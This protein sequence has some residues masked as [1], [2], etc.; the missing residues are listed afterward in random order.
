MTK[1]IDVDEVIDYTKL[2]RHIVGAI[3]RGGPM[4]K[5]AF[6][7]R[8][9]R[10]TCGG[11]AFVFA[12]TM[13]L[14][15]VSAAW[16]ESSQA[17]TPSTASSL[18]APA[19]WTSDTSLE[20]SAGA[21][22]ETAISTDSAAATQTA[23]SVAS[24]TAALSTYLPQLPDASTPLAAAGEDSSP[25]ILRELESSRT[26]ES[27]TYLMSDGSLRA[28][29]YEQ[30]IHFRNASGKWQDI[31]ASLVP[32]GTT[33]MVH[34]KSS[35]YDE[36]I[37]SADVTDTP[38]SV[39]HGDWSL[40]LR[41]LGAEQGTLSVLGDT[42][43]YPLAMSDTQL[44]Y[45]TGANKLK[46]T[47]VL[48]SKDAPDTFTFFMSVDNL[49]V[50]TDPL[51]GYVLYDKRN[52]PAGRIEPLSVFDS[53]S[54][55]G[56]DDQG[57]VCE[58]ANMKITPAEGGAYVSYS[59]SRKWLDDPARVYP[60]QV[61]P[62]IIFGGSDVSVDTFVASNYPSSSFGSADF[63]YSGW[64][65]PD[66]NGHPTWKTCRSIMQF[67]L[68]TILQG[69]N[70]TSA[71]LQLW[72]SQSTGS[73][74]A[75]AHTVT[76]GGWGSGSTWTS[77]FGN[78]SLTYLA[79]ASTTV[80]G[81]GYKAWEIGTQVQRWYDGTQVNHGL[82]V[83]ESN[84]LSSA[85]KYHQY[86]SSDNTVDPSSHT[87]H[88]IVNYTQP[89]VAVSGI[90]STYHTGDNVTA[91]VTVVS[92]KIT[93][94][95]M[96]AMA[97]GSQRGLFRF[98][99]FVPPS[100]W[101]Y[102][103]VSGGY[104]SY[105]PNSFPAGSITPN[106]AAC[107]TSVG[108][109]T[110]TVNFVYGIGAEYGAL[111][112]TSIQVCDYD[113]M[114]A[115]V[116]SG[117]YYS[118]IPDAVGSV[119]SESTSTSGWFTE[120]DT[121]ADGVNDLKDDTTTGRGSVDLSWE[122]ANNAASYNIYLFDGVKYDKVGSTP[123]TEWTTL[124]KAI[125]PGDTAISNLA[126]G[127]GN[128]PFPATG[129]KDLR[130]DP[131]PLYSKM[132]GSV[133]NLDPKYYFKVTAVSGTNETPVS[134][135][136]TA[137]P[138]TLPNRSIR[139]NDDPQHAI[140][141][142]GA[143]LF[144][145]QGSA[146]LERGSLELDVTDLS[147]AS[148]GP[149]A[150]LSRHYSSALTTATTYAPGWRFNFEKSLISQG[151]TKIYTDETGDVHRFTNRGGTWVAPNGLTAALA[152]SGSNWTITFKDRS[153]L[154]FN[155]SGQLISESDAHG[156]A[157]TVYYTWAVGH[158]YITAANGQ[159]IDVSMT[160][161]PGIVT[162]AEYATADGTRV[163]TYDGGS[164]YSGVNPTVVTDPEGNRIRY[165][166]GSGSPGYQ[167]TGSPNR[168]VEMDAPDFLWGYY[169][170]HGPG[171]NYADIAVAWNFDYD[172]SSRLT[173]WNLAN[174][175][176]NNGGT[177]LGV[178]S[179]AYNGASATVTKDGSDSTSSQT[180]SW[181]PN[182]QLSSESA[183]LD[184]SKSWS[185]VYGPTM[186]EVFSSTPLEHTTASVLD[187]HD[188]VLTTTDEIEQVASHTYDVLDRELTSTDPRGSIETRLYSGSDLATETKSLTTTRTAVTAWSHNASGAVTQERLKIDE[189][190]TAVTDYSA[191]AANGTPQTT[192]NR[193]VV[194]SFGANAQDLTSAKHYDSFGNL[195]WEKNAAGKWVTKNNTYTISGHLA[196][197]EIVTG[198]VTTYT[199]DA[200]GGVFEKI[201][202]ANGVVADSVNTHR[203]P[204]GV[205]TDQFAITDPS[206]NVAESQ[207]SV[208][209]L[210]GRVSKTTFSDET[211]F[212][213][214]GYSYVTY[215][216]EGHTTNQ[217]DLTTSASQPPTTEAVRTS[218]DAE[219]RTLSSTAPGSTSAPTNT[220][221]SAAGL[222]T[223]VENA[224][225]SWETK[226]YDASGN[227]ITDTMSKADD[228][229]ATTYSSYDLDGRCVETTDAAGNV[230]NYTYDLAGNQLTAGIKTHPSSTSTYN[231][232]GW[233]LSKTDADGVATQNTYDAAGRLTLT[234]VGGEQTSSVYDDAGNLLSQ[235]DPAGATVHYV[236]DAFS[237]K[238]REWHESAAHVNFRDI[239]AAY[240]YASH[241]TET[242]R[243]VGAA[244]IQ[245]DTFNA[246][247]LL[248]SSVIS[249]GQTTS[250]VDYTAG[251]GTENARTVEAIGAAP[252]TRTVSAH[253][254]K[255]A[256]AWNVTGGLAGSWTRTF[257]GGGHVATQDGTGL[258]SPAA[259][260][261][262]DDGRKSHE[263][264]PFA[265]G[266]TLDAGYTYT[267]DGRLAS[268]TGFGAG[269][270]AYDS[271]GNLT[272]FTA[273]VNGSESTTSGVLDYDSAGRL[274][275]RFNSDKSAVLETFGLDTARGWRTNQKRSG[276]TTVTYGY[277]DAGH[278]TV[279]HKPANAQGT[280]YSVDAAYEYDAL[281]QR[282]VS[283]VVTGSV[284]TT[285]TWTYDGLHLD[286]LSA[287]SSAGQTWSV[288]YLY[289]QDG[290]PFAGVYRSSTSSPVEFG[291]LTTDR[292]DVAELTDA[293]GTVFASYRYDAWGR[294]LSVVTQGTGTVS[295]AL[296]ATIAS[297]QPLRYAGY[298]Y[299]SESGLYYL[300][301]RTYDPATAQFLQKDPATADGEESAYQYCGGDPVGH[302]DPSG[303]YTSDWYPLSAWHYEG[304][305][306]Y[307]DFP[308]MKATIVSSGMFFPVGLAISVRVSVTR[309]SGNDVKV[310]ARWRRNK[311]AL[312]NFG[313][314]AGWGLNWGT[315]NFKVRVYD[316]H[317][318][319]NGRYADAEAPVDGT[320][321]DNLAHSSH[322][323][324]YIA[325][326]KKIAYVRVVMTLSDDNA[327]GI[328]K[329]PNSTSLDFTYKL[330][331]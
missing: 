284:T 326:R 44:L 289:A 174:V 90:A 232:L 149:S 271:G 327:N 92:K 138:A 245:H 220:T 171:Q 212:N 91:T 311:H 204:L 24:A 178:N 306:D 226:T 161:L 48:S 169:W 132:T 63:F 286:S 300:S 235:T 154:T 67:N 208:I 86:V 278:L 60:V 180:L 135:A 299:D 76:S 88:L 146:D 95:Q 294:P 248:S 9:R 130:D 196:T 214:I 87:P 145:H 193:G 175:W 47:L 52:K 209:D 218:Y 297:R 309:K 173:E 170:S 111:G 110:R 250:T 215:D 194:L 323:S 35:A 69:A 57:A 243:T 163:V 26:A 39:T 3:Q 325:S 127:T 65:I 81:T 301:A 276:E 217:W 103:A 189:G 56:T 277:D 129:G 78:S 274:A 38:V 77:T 64:V 31:D 6:K 203:T 100:P 267:A 43:S 304:V 125:Y 275:T 234:S 58:D 70:V 147:I 207:I 281:G 283:V 84:D 264:L 316:R 126:T 55:S 7:A 83:M 329:G 198:T 270:F 262:E 4:K 117:S 20:A 206:G 254:A 119:S 68:D 106:L 282:L 315:E 239:H 97:G 156:G 313:G 168:L 224:D 122:A 114:S 251:D 144:H 54:G 263:R 233:V 133:T 162:R 166:F 124:G 18:G 172:G 184:S 273:T 30:A 319:S 46:D 265:L 321:N 255:R 155:A 37:A 322:W 12:S 148:W 128:N 290:L 210:A 113:W 213:D 61:D 74:T 85:C 25:T 32:S 28:E 131:R 152:P 157:A 181:Y 158:L 66:A 93:D 140:Y 109:G 287:T 305:A 268:V 17:Q 186:A 23:A 176:T 293:A 153:V 257:D 141:E 205:V 53:A 167:G 318:N 15:N 79:G 27:S 165:Y 10:I 201:T 259:Y 314:D 253:D 221:Y 236:Y 331:P 59:V 5:A 179:I 21:P 258:S 137:G 200:L 11:M 71:Q 280:T 222:V 183:L 202:A 8:I 223:H 151:A 98:T 227:Q 159:V 150:E 33:G 16:A 302:V 34:T 136:A 197:S 291:I 49:K 118:V 312:V 260:T 115:F 51:G 99:T 62:Q 14:G 238:T 123:D 187:A 261:Y 237:R 295:S 256:T 142:L 246:Q 89:T 107:T 240:N 252:F 41:L 101:L 230:T 134:S 102:Q 80:S 160:G 1:L 143:D 19:A 177:L 219:G 244:V 45:E 164:G 199:Y 36:T 104:V 241:V 292:G 269:T 116:D 303:L 328:A 105:D 112:Q 225:G 75:Y 285:T 307:A 308:Q 108:S 192:I 22:A 228:T 82:L 190:T 320:H 298:V 94:L 288:A 310:T 96:R 50:Y 188:N 247:G 242:S 231:T 216:E 120:A 29:I 296:A 72:C 40:G 121:N 42:A 13:V 211:Q 185:W 182:A 139:V 249:Y 279:F 317:R 266:G 229:G 195:I 272:N 191:F 330:N 73:S 324:T 2:Q